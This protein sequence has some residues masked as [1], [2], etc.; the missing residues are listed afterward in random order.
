M[1]FMQ[2]LFF[3]SVMHGAYS[4]GSKLLLAVYKEARD[5]VPARIE[6][7]LLIELAKRRVGIV[8]GVAAAFAAAKFWPATSAFVAGVCSGYGTEIIAYGL[9]AAL[10]KAKPL[11]NSAATGGKD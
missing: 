1:L 3:L 5:D 11:P 10:K 6:R 4:V 7:I 2:Y 8:V 9:R